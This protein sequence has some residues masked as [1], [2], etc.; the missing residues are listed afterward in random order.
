[1]FII[2]TLRQLRGGGK[3]WKREKEDGGN[4]LGKDIS[5]NNLRMA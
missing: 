1:M 4:I 5:K 3:A 2:N